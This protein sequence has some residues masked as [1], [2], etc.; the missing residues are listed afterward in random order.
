[1]NAIFDTSNNRLMAAFAP[2]CIW[3]NG[4]LKESNRQAR[5][6]AVSEQQGW[7]LNPHVPFSIGRVSFAVIF[8]LDE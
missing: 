7:T 3:G 5:D 8:C 2:V 1:M 4:D 6:Q